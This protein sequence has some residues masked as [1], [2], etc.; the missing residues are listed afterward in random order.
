MDSAPAQVCIATRF[1]HVRH[2]IAI[3][4]SHGSATW[5]V[6]Y[7]H[8]QETCHWISVDRCFVYLQLG[9]ATATT[10]SS[11]HDLCSEAGQPHLQEIWPVKTGGTSMMS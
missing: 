9:I 1:V 5:A 4:S 2:C 11:V 6:K 7:A 3:A 10:H 8:L